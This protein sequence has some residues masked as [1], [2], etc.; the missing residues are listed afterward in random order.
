MVQH[1][2]SDRH[3]EAAGAAGERGFTMIEMMIAMTVLLAGI[4]GILS[5][6]LSGYRATAY[7]RHATE[8][9]ILGEGKMEWLLVNPI[10]NLT[11]GT[12]RV[13]ARGVLDEEG[14]YAREWSVAADGDGM[15]LD[16]TVSWLEQGGESHSIT[17]SSRRND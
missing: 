8:A 17:M 9:S 16:V 13:D 11:S 4:A 10:A 5:L 7:S 3:R 12:D 1:V 2:T 15:A 6:Q 14:L